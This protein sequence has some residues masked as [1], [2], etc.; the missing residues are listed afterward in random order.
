[1]LGLPLVGAERRSTLRSPV[2]LWGKIY[3]ASKRITSKIG[4]HCASLRFTKHDY[5]K[6]KLS[7]LDTSDD[8][9]IKNCGLVPAGQNVS[10]GCSTADNLKS[11]RSLEAD[12]PAAIT[13]DTKAVKLIAG[14]CCRSRRRFVSWSTRGGRWTEGIDS[15]VQLCREKPLADPFSRCL[16]VFRSSRATSIRV[17]VYDGQGFWLARSGFPKDDLCGGRTAPSRRVRLRRIKRSC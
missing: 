11:F 8:G 6:N 4:L 9:R 5:L 15:L 16:I 3:H 10:H 13:P 12:A 2:F 1:M 17:L 7:C 14:E